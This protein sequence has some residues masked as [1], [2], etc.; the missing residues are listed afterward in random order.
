MERKPT[1][2]LMYTSADSTDYTLHR[3]W[4]LQNKHTFRKHAF[5]GGGS[6]PTLVSKTLCQTRMVRWQTWYYLEQM[7]CSICF[8]G[9][10]VSRCTLG[11][12][13]SSLTMRKSNRSNRSPPWNSTAFIWG[14]GY[15]FTSYDL[16]TAIEFLLSLT[17][18]I[19]RVM[20]FKFL[21]KSDVSF[22]KV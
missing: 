3:Y 15:D 8:I 6:S 18:H 11:A 4:C 21:L 19:A 7:P 1:L 5:G 14:F 9:S 12:E 10:L 13:V 16:R 22:L 20:K 17:E 2:L